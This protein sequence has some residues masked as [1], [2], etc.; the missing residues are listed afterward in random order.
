MRNLNYEDQEVYEGEIIYDD[1]I[2]TENINYKLGRNEV[3][4]LLSE[5]IKV[6]EYQSS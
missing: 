5:L 1:V 2:D 4:T 3:L 6:K